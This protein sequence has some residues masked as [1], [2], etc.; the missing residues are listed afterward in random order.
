MGT[1]IFFRLAAQDP[2]YLDRN[3]STFI[4]LG[5]VIVPANSTAPLVEATRHHHERLYKALTSSFTGLYEIGEPTRFSNYAVG[6]ICGNLR[7][8]CENALSMIASNEKDLS[9]EDRFAVFMGHYPAGGSTQVIFHYLQQMERGEATVGFD[10]YDEVENKSRYG[11]QAS[12]PILSMERLGE[13]ELPISLFVG[14]ND[15]LST[16]TDDRVIRD[17]IQPS[18]MHHYEEIEADHLS[19]LLGKDMTFWT[20]RA[21]DIL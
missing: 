18:A 15:I 10:Y 9:D 11:G 17:L 5:P 12:P 2:D 16:P 14:E 20:E 1:T 19:L 21:M 4:G 6:V 7:L 3:V 13:L 8:P